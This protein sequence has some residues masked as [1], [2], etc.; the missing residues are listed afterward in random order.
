MINRREF[1]SAGA[2]SIGAGLLAR[3]VGAAA[4]SR[5]TIEVLLNEPVGTI[6][7]D[8]YG[9]LLENLGTVIYD[10]V[11]VG[12]SSKIPNIGGIRKDLIERMRDIKASVIRWPGGDFADD[13]DWKDGV[14]PRASRPRRRNSWSDA[15][16]AEV[17]AGPQRYDPNQFGTPEFMRLCKLSGGRPFLGV[18][19]RSLTPQ[20]FSRWIEYCNAPA[21]STT[22]ADLRKADGSAEPYGVRYWSIGNEVWANGGLMTV[23]EYANEYKR[24][25][26]GAPTYGIEPAFI[27]CGPPPPF[28]GTEWIGKFLSLCCSRALFP[29]PVFAISLHYYANEPIN[30]LP[31]NQTAAE[32]FAGGTAPSKRLLDAVRF[33][34]NE[35]YEVLA[36]S[37]RME[38][39]IA[40][41]WEEM[42]PGDPN[43]KIKISVDEWATLYK[44]GSG[45]GPLNVT[46]Q[47]ATLRDALAAALT[48][49]IFHGQCDK[50]ALA[51][52]TGLINIH[53]GLFKAQED[54]FLTTPIYH[55]FQMYASHQGGKALR[56]VFDAPA[57]SYIH[58]GKPAS[59][60][61]LSG[62]ASLQGHELTL[63]VVNSH[64][65]EPQEPSITLRGGEVT[66]GTATTLTNA[67]IH[68]Q[69]TFG[70]PEQVR[71]ITANAKLSGSNFNHR[72]PPCS[73][74][75]LTLNL[76]GGS[77]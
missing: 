4:S 17:A 19:L 44:P 14:G 31:L 8:L 12:E 56:S 51:N 59:L 21:D 35:W 23:E 37:A 65:S 73:V 70:D 69:N 71:P 55:V 38:D 13:Y 25:T 45:L 43:R 27:A 50:I 75:R 58:A 40:S 7:P 15:M 33:D 11:W 2:C 10:G 16:P 68:A 28:K 30:A 41:C 24:F 57:I 3:S 22:L 60:P 64:V 39:L 47:A 46:G 36:N 52:F 66:S 9:Y 74:T 20:D 34:A 62:S 42:R 18:N 5:S 63:T 77:G 54:R 76:R 49:D 53:C 72:F 1:V 6:S 67:D 61:T 26:A 32:F 48:L 29:A